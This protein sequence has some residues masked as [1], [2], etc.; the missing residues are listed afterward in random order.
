M[1]GQS[2][3]CCV[4]QHASSRQHLLSGELVVIGWLGTWVQTHAGLRGQATAPAGAG[5]ISTQVMRRVVVCGPGWPVC[6]QFPGLPGQVQAGPASVTQPHQPAR[7]T[8]CV[9]FHWLVKLAPASLFAAQHILDPADRQPRRSRYGR[10]TRQKKLSVCEKSKD[11][12]GTA[13]GGRHPPRLTS[14]SRGWDSCEQPGA[15]S[16]LPVRCPVIPSTK[17]EHSF[18]TFLP[19]PL[20]GTP[21]PSVPPPLLLLPPP[22]PRRTPMML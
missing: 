11:R 5:G 14:S 1:Q 9:Q 20:E 16:T 17:T 10:P 19:P 2:L 21:L 22:A 15:A 18:T 3:A 8:G 7:S 12:G 13:E 4:A 6:S